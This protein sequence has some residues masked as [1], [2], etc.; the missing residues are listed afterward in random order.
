[1][2]RRRVILLYI[3]IIGFFCIGYGNINISKIKRDIV[4]KRYS[5][6][7]NIMRHDSVFRRS[8]SPIIISDYMLIRENATLT[9]E[10]GTRVLFKKK[11]GIVCYG[12][13]I[14]NG[15][16]EQ[17]ITF[18]SETN[19]RESTWVNIMLFGA[20]AGKSIFSNCIIS[21][22][23]GVRYDDPNPP[24]THPQDPQ[25]FKP[26]G[27]SI[28]RNLLGGGAIICYKASPTIKQCIFTNNSAPG[29]G[30][31]VAVLKASAPMITKNVFI[32]NYSLFHGGAI[33]SFHASPV[34]EQNSFIQN[35][36]GFNGGAVYLQN[37]ASIQLKNNTFTENSSKLGGAIF[38]VSDT[39][40][41]QNNLFYA[42]HA[43]AGG[44]VMG[45]NSAIEFVDSVFEGN[46]ADFSGGGV[47]L[48]QS[49]AKFTGCRLTGN[50]AKSG[51]MVFG[52]KSQV[53]KKNS[54]FSD[55]EPNNIEGFASQASTN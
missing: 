16:P 7:V 35:R 1:M 6:A 38:L 46:K 29:H 52:V 8:E 47:Y 24:G 9:I 3:T 4:G 25:K 55:N 5:G 50:S 32:K 15:T 37:R 26:T 41:M 54:R 43:S 31:A 21:G 40:S 22:A 39:V 18:T 34:I 30:G 48:S 2:T 19:S 36:S 10:A 28:N 11:I 44:G 45:M 49:Q 13:I 27:L 33:Y 42:N 12:R 53:E 14:A 51:G 17:K 23:G 20:K